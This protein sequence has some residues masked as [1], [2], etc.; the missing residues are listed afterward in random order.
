MA[1]HEHGGH[2]DRM[3][4]RFLRGGLEHFAPH[5]V[6]ELLLFYAIP[7]RNVNPLAHKLVRHFGSVAA[8]LE[9]SP[10]QLQQVEGIGQSTATYISLILSATRYAQREQQQTERSVL[11]N[12][13]YAMDY[14]LHL[15]AGKTDE[16]LYVICL[17]A[18][19]R[20]L[21][22]AEAVRGTIDEVPIYPRTVMQI[23]LDNRAYSILL[24][25][26][27]PSGVR[28]PSQADLDTTDDLRTAMA[29]F[30]IRLQD[31]I[32]YADGECLSMEQ[33]K[34]DRERLALFP[35]E[36]RS[37]AADKKTGTRR[38]MKEKEDDEEEPT[39]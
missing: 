12:Y 38:M 34:R 4:E 33:W 6:L 16:V 20:V 37:R 27:H 28:E 21:R 13:R 10:E 14:C 31:H 7:R 17:D 23:A 25:H 2:R 22:A 35:L 3:R 30:G 19:G 1:E 8:V 36:K 5:E 32:I 15:F 26:N 39:L 29:P 18:Q 24:A 11:G 9:A